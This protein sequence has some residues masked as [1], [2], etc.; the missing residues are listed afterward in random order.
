MYEDLY[1]RREDV[2]RMIQDKEI[3]VTRGD[4]VLRRIAA[5]LGEE[6]S[7]SDPLI[8]QWERELAEGKIP[9]LEAT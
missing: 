2:Q 6:E 7:T 9:D 1:E 3:S 8:D 5:A 4:E